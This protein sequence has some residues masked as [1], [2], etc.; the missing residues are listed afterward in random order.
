MLK[1]NGVA[2]AH[3]YIGYAFAIDRDFLFRVFCGA[4]HCLP[5]YPMNSTQELSGARSD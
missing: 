5:Q 2:R 4:Y 3:L 1:D